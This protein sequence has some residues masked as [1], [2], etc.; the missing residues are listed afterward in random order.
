MLVLGISSFYHDSGACLLEDGKI[1]AAVQE[2]RFTRIKQ[3][4]NFPY[5][6]I[7]YCLDFANITI[8]QVDHVVF[9]EKPKLK[10][11]RIL[12]TFLSY[13]PKDY[14][15]FGKVMISQYKRWKLLNEKF[16][17]LK[18]VE[19]HESHSAS[20][21]YPSPFDKAVV[22]TLDGVGE[23][24]TAS[25]GIGIDNKLKL[26]QTLKFP[27]SLGFLYSAFTYFC[28][29]KVNSGEY[30]LMGLAPYGKPKY[31]DV[32][33][34]NLIDLRDDGSF[35]LNLEYFGYCNSDYM[36][37]DKFCELFGGPSRESESR[38][39]QRE[40]D[41]AASIQ[42]VIEDVIF[43]ICK[44]AKEV[45][46]QENLCLAGGV[47]LNCVSNGKLLESKLFKNIWIQPAAG[48][49]GGA[50]GAALHYYHSVLGKDRLVD[51]SDSMQG[52]YLG[53]EFTNKEI[54]EFLE[55]NNIKYKYET[56]AKLI[57][58]VSKKI[59][60]ENVIGWFQG[61]MEFGPRALG[62]RSIIGDARS[63]KMQSVMNLKIKFRES[64]RP[65]AP[66]VLEE[67]TKKYFDLDTP[68]PYMLLVAPIADRIRKT[69]KQ[70]KDTDLIQKV[71]EIRSTIPS[72]T[73]V[74][75]SAR[76]QT[77]NKKTNRRLYDLLKE[78]KKNTSCSVLVNTSFNVRG[79]PIVCTPYDA[80]NCFML[81]D[82][83]YLI[84]GNYILDKTE[85]KEW[86]DDLK[87]DYLDKF[88]LD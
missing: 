27:D 16:P 81:T 60:N 84:M 15:L 83:D 57:S 11:D 20:A 58:K 1:K 46:G 32:I 78:F 67:D 12:K 2:E 59:E 79:E 30:K 87:K 55:K 8:D 17:N 42:K 14:N 71:N 38:L 48:D 13:K 3:D 33:M 9:Y 5:K 40:V 53:P 61:R 49:A 62:S 64:F 66:I 31:Y 36:I 76:I 19:H 68:S 69:V 72:V 85:Q 37:N 23:W 75:Y 88:E 34:E 86:N 25:I 52:S 7:E 18:F 50:L 44:N 70:N 82:M 54:K 28:G 6:S 65:F 47:A 41:L 21:F 39:T 77:V 22:I 10:L 35:S 26:I 45:T 56:N 29:F 74:D 43:K 24:D 73:H 80:Y 4:N 51:K 63:S